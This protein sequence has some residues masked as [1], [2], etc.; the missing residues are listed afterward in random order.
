VSIAWL[1]LVLLVV[2]VASLVLL[3]ITW[4]YFFARSGDFAE[5]L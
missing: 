2:L 3:R 4:G 1:A 5:E